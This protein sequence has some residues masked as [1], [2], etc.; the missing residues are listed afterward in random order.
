MTPASLPPFARR[1]RSWFDPS[2]LVRSRIDSHGHPVYIVSTVGQPVKSI[3]ALSDDEL[4]NLWFEASQVLRQEL[5]DDSGFVKMVFACG[6]YR[7]VPHAHLQI[8]VEEV[9]NRVIIFRATQPADG[10]L[11]GV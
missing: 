3:S 1:R 5:P 7:E 2:H 6:R 11:S 8:H 9:T 10:G 4:Y